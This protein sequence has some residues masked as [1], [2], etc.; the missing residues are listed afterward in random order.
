MDKLCEYDGCEAQAVYVTRVYY[1]F[2]HLSNYRG[3]RG[4][5]LMVHPEVLNLID[6]QL[7]NIFC[8]LLYR[9][10]HGVLLH[11]SLC[12]HFKWKDRMYLWGSYQLDTLWALQGRHCVSNNRKIDCLFNNCQY[13][14]MHHTA[15]S[16]E[17]RVKY[18]HGSICV[19]GC[20]IDRKPYL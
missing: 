6:F 3:Y 5:L 8:I 16:N 11:D 18:I 17:C 15:C 20:A 7:C 13:I 1:R 2:M 14:M 10:E 12:C 9:S 19:H 4:L